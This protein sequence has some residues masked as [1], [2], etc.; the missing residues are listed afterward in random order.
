LF[1]ISPGGSPGIL[2]ITGD[3]TQAP[4][5]VL[6]IEIGGLTPGA[7]F[8]RLEVSDTATLTDTLSISLT[9]GFEPALGD[10]FEILTFSARSGDF[11]TIEGLGIGPDRHF[12]PVY[13]NHALTLQVV[14][15]PLG[16]GLD[17]LIFLP[18]ILR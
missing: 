7:E 15:G 8:D 9:N 10:S 13:V 18:I 14:E 1:Y 17:H 16:P 2:H 6:D 5:G 11:T 3:F 12:E 4:T